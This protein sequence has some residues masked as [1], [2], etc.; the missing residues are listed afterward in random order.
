VNQS[1]VYSKI[2]LKYLPHFN[3]LKFSIPQFENNLLRRNAV[4]NLTYKRIILLVLL[5][6]VF[7]LALVKA[8]DKTTDMDNPNSRQLPVEPSS[9]LKVSSKPMVKPVLD[10]NKQLKINSATVSEIAENL[11]GIGETIARRI[12]LKRQQQGPFKNFE[13]LKAVSGVGSAKIQT[14]KHKISFE[15]PEPKN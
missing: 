7:S 8:F 14:N 12:V 9:E 11:E 13:Q 10:H 1:T 6:I 5:A 3:S 4:K 2:M 15:L